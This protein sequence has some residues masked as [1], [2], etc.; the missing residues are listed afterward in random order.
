MQDLNN[1]AYL[2]PYVEDNDEIFL[3]TRL[4]RAGRQ[5]KDSFEENMK[6]RLTKEEKEIVKGFENGEWVTVTDF[7]RRK[8][9]LMQSA[10]NTLK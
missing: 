3:K 8:K 9:E 1:Y 5:R 6:T 4:S 2:I 7:S 10:R